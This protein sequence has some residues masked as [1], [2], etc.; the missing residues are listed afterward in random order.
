MEYNTARSSLKIREFGRNVQKLV[1]FAGTIKDDEKRNKFIRGIIKLM[2]QMY[3][4]MGNVEEF[5]QQLWVHL[6]ILSDYSLKMDCPFPLPTKKE[7]DAKVNKKID[8]PQGKVRYFQ[9]GANVKSMIEKAITIEDPEKQKAF[10][11]AIGNYMKLVY[12]NWNQENV[13]DETI[14]GDLARM[15]DGKL[16]LSEDS[17]LDN[18]TRSSR[19]NNPRKKKTG[20]NRGGKY[21]KGNTQNKGRRQKRY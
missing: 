3:P 10:A 5:Q 12:R 15:S 1:D 21:R 14:L 20:S 4:G 9:Y 8:Y 16:Q 2:N 6:Y 13:S 7:N 18:L 19:S 17:N 11:E